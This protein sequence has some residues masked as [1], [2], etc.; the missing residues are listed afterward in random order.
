MEDYR[1]RLVVVA[2]GYPG[3]MSQFVQSNPGL[4]S[5]FTR[6]LQFQ[7]YTPPEL[8]EIFESFAA[9]GKYEIEPSARLALVALLSH[10][11]EARDERFGNGRTVRNIFGETISRQHLRLASTGR[12]LE[13]E[14]LRLLT[15]EDIP[16]TRSEGM[17]ENANGGK[18][19]DTTS[20]AE[21]GAS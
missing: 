11:Y 18:S 6:F 2:A 1:D 9:A 19:T 21:H 15:I 3:P 14:E 10:E 12:P 8:L 13:R 7:D 4:R 17:R 16:T 5:R 20:G